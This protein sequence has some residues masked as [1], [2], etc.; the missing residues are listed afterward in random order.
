MFWVF[1]SSDT[2][3]KN[4]M[5]EVAKNLQVRAKFWRANFAAAWDC[6]GLGVVCWIGVAGLFA[7]GALLMRALLMRRGAGAHQAAV[8]QEI[9]P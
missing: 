8:P 1:K 7:C 6:C 2:F 9:R 3:G 4:V 5:V